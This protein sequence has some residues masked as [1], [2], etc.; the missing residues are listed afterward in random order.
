MVRFYLL[1]FVVLCL[2]TSCAYSPTI[3]PQINSLSI[4]NKHEAAIRIL[5]NSQVNYGEQNQ[6]LY[7]MDYG[8]LLH[9]AGR[10]EES[11]SV[12]EEAKREYDR[13]F[14]TSLSKEA[15]TWLVNDNVSPYR[16]EDFERVMINIF[17]AVNY[18][19]TGDINEAL[20]EARDV[21]SLLRA[22]NEQYDDGQKNLYVE[23]AFARFFMGLLYEMAGT[24]EYQN[25]A[26]ISYKKAWGIYQGLFQP[27]YG[28]GA[29]DILKENLLYLS[30]KFDP[31]DDP[32]YQK[33]F[34]GIDIKKLDRRQNKAEIIIVHYK[35]LS[36]V[37][38]QTTIVIP[39]GAG[40]LAKLAFPKYVKREV[41]NSPSRCE[42]VSQNG[43][44]IIAVMEIAHDITKIAVQNLECR[45]LRIQAKSTIRSVGKAVA[46]YY[47]EDAVRRSS[48]DTGGDLFRYAGSLYN[49]SSEQADLRSWQTLPAS[50][51]VSRVL[52]E[53]GDYKIYF[54]GKF[55][56]Q[57]QWKAGERDLV[58]IR[59]AQW[60]YD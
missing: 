35:G 25:D 30:K 22:M 28:V 20:V 50:I 7:L 32:F 1:A 15:G 51:E 31:T 13:L 6:L 34:A 39:Y 47:V 12:F 10:F 37:K 57:K 40:R 38:N 48:G 43:Q 26:Y 45:K 5:E 59:S 18:A 52:L 8:L 33:E 27:L 9:Y 21:D 36:P 56:S 24:F 2:L 19:K 44:R 53:P 14:T 23:D 29:P 42:I 3:Q 58:V 54:N 60:Q 41:D 46:S 17:Q 11:I 4:A 49:L 16:G 55:I